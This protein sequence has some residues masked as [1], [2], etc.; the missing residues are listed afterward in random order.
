MR[1]PLGGLLGGGLGVDAFARYTEQLWFLYRAPE[2]GAGALRGDPAA[3]GPRPRAPG[4]R[5]QGHAPSL[6]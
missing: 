2:D 4:P 1:G 6:T 3:P 5:S